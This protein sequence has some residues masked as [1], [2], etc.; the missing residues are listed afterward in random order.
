MARG[1]VNEG[2]DPFASALQR[3]REAMAQPLPEL[4]PV[5]PVNNATA[6]VSAF[7]RDIV[8]RFP[9]AG[10]PSQVAALHRAAAQDLRRLRQRLSR[11]RRWL[12]VVYFLRR[13][14]LA[15]AA[16]LILLAGAYAIY[17]YLDEIR[18]FLDTILSPIPPSAPSA[19][20]DP[21]ATP[22]QTDGGPP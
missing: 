18:A 5:H 16:G 12:A 9:H 6:G 20:P 10:P 19:P 17:F 3:G 21:T 1:T 15:I 2:G 14:G 11:R 22:A 7:R 13:F 4:P 8:A